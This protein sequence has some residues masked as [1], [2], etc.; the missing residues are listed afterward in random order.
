MSRAQ[1]EETRRGLACTFRPG[2]VGELLQVEGIS[3]KVG[4][5]VLEGLAV[6]GGDR[7]ADKG[8]EARSPSLKELLHERAGDGVLKH[9]TR[10]Q[11]LSE[12]RPR[13]QE[14]RDEKTPRWSKAPSVTRR[15]RCGFHWRI[16]LLR[17]ITLHRIAGKCASPHARAMAHLHH[18]RHRLCLRH[19]RV[20]DASVDQQARLGDSGAFQFRNSGIQ[21]LARSFTCRR[22]R[23]ASSDC[24]AAI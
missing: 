3:D 16:K 20:A 21:L 2:D 17:Q 14:F 7:L 24:W 10:E 4:G 5:D 6:L 1:V 23:G 8:R 9:K 19:V 12:R 18:R 15:C 11:T 22:F 13:S